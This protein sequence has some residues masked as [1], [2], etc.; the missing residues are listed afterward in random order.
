MNLRLNGKLIALFIGCT[1]SASLW[2]QGASSLRG[3]VTDPQKGVLTDAKVT[4]TDKESGATRAMLTTN[5]GGYQFLQ[6]RPGAYSVSVEAAG[7]TTK[8]IADVHLLVDTPATLDISLEIASTTSTVNVTAE[9]A[10]LNDVDA[11]V[12]NAFEL[13]QVESLPLQTRNVVQLLSLQPG[14]TQTGEVMG[15]RRDQ[16]NILLD[17]VDNNDNQNPLSGISGTSS[18]FNSTSN[19]GFT[20]ALPIPL[21]SVEEFRVTVAGQSAFAGHSSGGQVALITR[22]GTNQMHGSAYEYNR[23]TDYTANNFFN[24]V[25]GLARPQLV[26]NQFGAS[27]GGPVKKNRVFYFLNY[28]RRIDSSQQSQSRLVPT[29]S[30]KQGLIKFKTTD[31]STYTL[32]P[33]DILAVDPLHIGETSTMLGLLKQYPEVNAPTLALSGSDSGLNFGG[34]LFNAPVKLDYRTYVAKMDWNVDSANK[35]IVSFRGTLSNFNETSTPAQFPGQDAASL[36]LQDNRGFSIRYTAILSSNLT[37]TANAG[38]TRIGYT[39]TGATGPSFALGAVASLQNY[40][41]R[42]STRINPTWNFNDDLNWVKGRHTVSTGVNFRWID[43]AL[44]SY[45]NSWPSYSMSR[46]V[47]LGLGQDIYT[48]AL[49][50]VANGNAALKLANSTA[51][52]NAF[53]DLLGTINSFSATYQYNKDGS[54]LPFGAPRGNDFV[55]HNYEFYIQ[56][57]WKVTPRLTVTYGLH[58][59]YDTPPYEVNGLQVATTPGLDAYFANRV[60]AQD[61]GIP[62]NQLPNQDRLTYTLN[63]PVNNQPSWY[64]PDKNNLAP[65]LALAYSI[66]PTTVF[67]AGAG[68]VYDT[69]GN[70]LV[71]SVSRLG[72]VGL[73]TTL[74]TPTSYNFTTSPRYGTGTL[75]TLQTAPQGGFPFTP[76]NIAAISGTY[77]GI[78]PSL[79]APYSYLLN[80]SLSHEFGHRYTVEAGYVGRYS[81]A[82]LIQEDVYA[83][84]IYF[85]DPKSG[86]NW[87][88]ASTTFYNLYNS[89]VSAAAVKANPSLVP[90]NA[91]VQDMFPGLANYYIP[92][93]ASANYFYGVYG[94]NNGSFLDNLHQLD[95]VT[96]AAF[97]NCISVTG[98]YT[99]FAPQGS[100]DPTWTNGGNANYNAMILTV[101]RALSSGVAFDFNYTW[102][103][104]IDNGSGVASGSGQFGGILQ[105]VFVPSLNRGSSDF[106]LRHQFNANFVYE[107]PFGK[108]KTFLR[109]SS[110]WMDA[111]VGGWQ[112]AGLVRVQS[113]LPVSM[114]GFGNFNSNYWNSSPGVLNGTMPATGVFTDNNGIPSLFKSTSAASQFTDAPPGGA[115]YRA[116]VRLPWQKNTD[117]TITKDFHLP[118][119]RQA[120]QLRADAFNAF[121]NVNFSINNSTTGGYSLSLAS[122]STFG[123]FSK[124]GDAR[125]LQLALRYSF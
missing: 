85:K 1:A 28:E 31:G 37:N 62:A 75:P 2:G 24:N 82:Q 50:Y 79:K 114:S 122:P 47:L 70:D 97:P 100:A 113:G 80:A 120:L 60:F 12:G 125:V 67:R 11:S 71:A 88:Q 73:S 103:H 35:H 117:L 110:K 84:L 36:L 86:Q 69:Y 61:N 29:D 49:N 3:V 106:D 9:A 94:I 98:C 68:V 15:A 104:S 13:K 57:S 111:L 43:N 112:L 53:G 21:D 59:E 7:F 116:I 121:N 58:Y 63:G 44:N 115:P 33:S 93:S 95:R 20:S 77:F 105:N 40:S 22:S 56:D 109:S 16:N 107:L 108:G 74:G 30:L 8:N 92:G 26:R 119:E 52:T 91:F 5:A 81:R 27:L 76:P 83:P 65:R 99:F 17:G 90:T 46:G 123:E 89:G 4:L 42:P 23:N 66:N 14:V 87:T 55:T 78:D 18:S 41:I 102:S 38:V 10:Q 19:S 34:Y 51:V 39:Q 45:T 118:W 48:D 6:L 96:S 124:A 32:T 72:S 25:S 54:I 64:K 101:R